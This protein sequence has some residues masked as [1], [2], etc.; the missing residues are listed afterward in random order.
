MALITQILP[1]SWQ[2]LQKATG[3]IL[4]EC[5]FDVEI[6]KQASGVRGGVELDVYAEETVKGRK[7]SIICECKYWKSNVPQTVVHSLRTVMADIGANAG[8]LICSS[9]FQSGA[10]AAAQNTSVTVV[11]WEQFQAFFCETW[12]I[13]YFLPKISTE[14]DSLFSY[15]EPLVPPWFCE[16]PKSD[17]LILRGLRDKYEEFGQFLLHLCYTGHEYF[18]F[19]KLPLRDKLTKGYVQVDSFPDKI[20]NAVGYRELLNEALAYGKTAI[21]EFTAV[22]ERNKM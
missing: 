8:Y 14:L 15:T 7:Y 3:Q 11:T 5:G 1:D 16:V 18:G 12:L 19:P 22:K 13:N 10:R 20:L 4:T 9:G 17:I 21:K 2:N 6:E